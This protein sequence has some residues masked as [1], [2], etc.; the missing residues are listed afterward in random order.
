[1]FFRTEHTRSKY[2]FI[3]DIK[4]QA[5]KKKSDDGCDKYQ[6][7]MP[8]G[9][10][11]MLVKFKNIIFYLSILTNYICWQKHMLWVEN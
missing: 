3:H 11:F 4:P 1:M 5:I 8:E 9:Q 10:A 6:K 2:N 7:I